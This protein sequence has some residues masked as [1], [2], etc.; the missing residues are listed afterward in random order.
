MSNHFGVKETLELLENLQHTVVDFATREEKFNQE[1][2]ASLNA[3]RTRREKALEQMS[4][5]LAEA[6]AQTDAD[7]QAQTDLV[8]S[9]YKTRRAWINRAQKA[10]QK[11]ALGGI[12]DREGRRKHKLQ[13]ETMQMHR[14]H[15]TGRATAEKTIIEFKTSLAQEL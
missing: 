13:T 14:N 3:E 9:K 1:F 7:F 6:V 2:N 8:E 12:E 11:Q 5:R 15:E 10:S 4:T